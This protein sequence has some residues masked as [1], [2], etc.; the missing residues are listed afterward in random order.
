MS[1]H[2]SPLPM[3]GSPPETKM[4]RPAIFAKGFRPFFFLAAL[5]AVLS[6]PVWM[7]ALYGF[8]RVD[9]HFDPM[10][11]HAHEMVFGFGA[12]VVAGFLLT[13]VGNWT[14]RETATGGHL[15]AL[16]A[17]WVAGRI[18]LLVPNLPSPLVTAVDVAFL[19]AIAITIARPLVAT[20]NRRNL[21]MALVLLL[22]SAVNVWMHLDPAG[23][24]RGA[25][26]GVDLLVI[27]IAIMA[28]RVFP[29]FTKNATGDATIRSH[30]VLDVLAIVSLVAMTALDLAS[31]SGPI[32]ALVCGGGAALMIARA[33][34]WGANRSARDPMLW[35][36]HAG[37]AWIPIG[38]LLRAASAISTTVP[39]ALATHALTAG[40]I[41]TVTLGM[42]ARVALGHTGR[43]IVAPPSARVAFVLVIAAAIARVI[44]PLFLPTAYR[45]CLIV[46]ALAWSGAFLAFL[47]GYT[48]VLLRPRIDGKSG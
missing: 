19:P 6:V 46:S 1:T 37:Y 43:K 34:H 48:S 9:A 8:V 15:A 47:A 26:L 11:W 23:R 40:A 4:R 29:M 24:R 36:L 35:I 31:Q 13:A 22:L 44:G 12:A 28:G 17:L 39:S 25:L 14:G 30:R 33:A 41:G 10:A 5:A 32:V 45:E 27:L 38:L 16:S 3:F 20:R 7:L 42:M 2:R 21:V 18:A